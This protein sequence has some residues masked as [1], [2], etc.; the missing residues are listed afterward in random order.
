MF[1]DTNK[2]GAWENGTAITPIFNITSIDEFGID[3]NVT[4]DMYDVITGELTVELS[5]GNYI[6]EMYEDSPRDENASDYRRSTYSLP[7]LDV[8]LVP[9]TESIDILLDPDY[10]ITGS[11]QMESGFAMANST[12][13]LRNDAGDDFYP[14]V[15]DANGTFA[16]Y[17]PVSYTHL[18]LPTK[19]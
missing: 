18:T 4:S 12:V 9:A 2:D 6:I 3:V 8:G 10:L 14:L 11:V 17:V 7:G 5:V 15:T 13:W 19:A 1:L 16:D